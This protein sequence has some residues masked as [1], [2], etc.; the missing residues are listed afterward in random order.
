MPIESPDL[1]TS[2]RRG[3]VFSMRLDPETEKLL[4]DRLAAH[5]R[6]QAQLP[7]GDE[8]REPYD[9]SRRSGSL[10]A[11]VIKMALKGSAA[12]KTTAPA[13]ASA[14]RP[15]RRRAGK[16]KRSAGRSSKKRT[17]VKRRARAR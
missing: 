17:K 15:R 1:N 12:G 6:A 11:F 9:Y 4:K 3:R 8:R 7:W 14:V 13:P 5:E 16:T 2:N 10:G